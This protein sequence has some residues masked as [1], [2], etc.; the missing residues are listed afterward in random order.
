MSRLGRRPRSRRLG[1]D[2][3]GIVSKR[4]ISV[5]RSGPSKTWIKDTRSRRNVLSDFLSTFVTGRSKPGT[6]L[7]CVR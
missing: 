7:F 4:P 2:L 1:F 6:S 3:E 5:Y